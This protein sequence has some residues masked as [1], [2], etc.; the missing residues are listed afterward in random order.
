MPRPESRSR[1]DA[2]M[3]CSSALGSLR[4]RAASTISSA[5]YPPSSACEKLRPQPCQ[6]S[7]PWPWLHTS[8]SLHLLWQ[9][10]AEIKAG[11]CMLWPQVSCFRT[12]RARRQRQGWAQT[13][14]GRG[15]TTSHATLARPPW[16]TLKRAPAEGAVHNGRSMIDHSSKLYQAGHLP[17]SWLHTGLHSSVSEH[18]AACWENGISPLP[19]LG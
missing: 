12:S 2:M 1:P 5:R 3:V 14:R 17:C 11:G 15:L 8:R 18:L 16:E 19:L 9:R 6:P 10:L 4:P 7:P 13:G